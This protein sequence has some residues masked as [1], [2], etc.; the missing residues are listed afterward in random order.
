MELGKILSQQ[1]KIDL[2]QPIYWWI[3]NSMLLQKTLKLAQIQ[4]IRCNCSR[5][6]ITLNC[7][8]LFE[9]LQ[10]LIHQNP[11]YRPSS[12][13]EKMECLSRSRGYASFGSLSATPG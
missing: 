13:I 7:H 3:E 12:S 9:S 8:M 1:Q 5:G 11:R 2:F 6:K 10:I 4:H